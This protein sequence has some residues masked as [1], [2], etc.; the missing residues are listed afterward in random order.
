MSVEPKIE[1]TDFQHVCLYCGKLNL[2]EKHREAFFGIK[3]CVNA[4]LK[5]VRSLKSDQDSLKVTAAKLEATIETHKQANTKLV[6]EYEE[7][8]CVEK[9]RIQGLEENLTACADYD[10]LTDNYN[11]QTRRFNIVS[12]KM[13]TII[14]QNTELTR[15]KRD[16]IDKVEELEKTAQPVDKPA[17]IP[18]IT[19]DNEAVLAKMRAEMERELKTQLEKMRDGFS[20][21]YEDMRKSF[22]LKVQPLDKKKT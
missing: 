7:K 19:V 20:Q 8:L 5:D 15:Q 14:K 3:G 10:K 9:E 21:Q 12:D 17:L 13:E 2:L 4:T 18:E 16:L 1:E 11:Q 22:A 6:V